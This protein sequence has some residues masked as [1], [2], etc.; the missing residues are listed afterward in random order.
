MIFN[1]LKTVVVRL[2]TCVLVVSFPVDGQVPLVK[3]ETPTTTVDLEP[4]SE[5]DL[6]SFV[7]QSTIRPGVAPATPKSL[8]TQAELEAEFGTEALV[9]VNERLRREVE[10]LAHDYRESEQQNLIY[11]L[12]VGGFIALV[13]LIFGFLLG[14]RASSRRLL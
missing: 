3:E 6:R 7:P 11:M 8:I 9:I 12:A 10:M 13:F 1:Q 5:S 2:A 4:V 14:R